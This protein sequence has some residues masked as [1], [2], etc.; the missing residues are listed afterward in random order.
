M[1]ERLK[2]VAQKLD[3]GIINALL[4]FQQSQNTPQLSMNPN[5]E[6]VLYK[7]PVKQLEAINVYDKEYLRRLVF[8]PS[9]HQ[10]SS[11]ILRGYK[12]T[13]RILFQS[14]K[15]SYRLIFKG[16]KRSVH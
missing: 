7:D 11:L 1:I 5:I 8:V 10:I 4:R 6:V 15:Y 3:H 2:T 14:A 16:Q 13:R 9:E 12:H